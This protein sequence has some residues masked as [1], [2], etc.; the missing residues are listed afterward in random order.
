MSPGKCELQQQWDST[1]H[2]LEWSKSRTLSTQNTGKEAEQLELSFIVCRNAEW[3]RHLQHN[4]PKGVENIGTYKSLHL[5]VYSSFTHSWQTLETTPMSFSRWKIK[6]L[7]IM[8]HCS[9]T[10]RNYGYIQPPKGSPGITLNK[11]KSSTE[12]DTNPFMHHAWNDKITEMGNRLMVA[13][14]W[15]LGLKL[16]LVGY[17]VVEKV[18]L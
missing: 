11:K 13:R 14:C 8:E 4:L 12:L 17:E 2:L 6:L 9:T 16:N 1:T 18:W 5:D 7:V 3:Y 15:R 10:R